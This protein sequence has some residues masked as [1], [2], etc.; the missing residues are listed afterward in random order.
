MG[1]APY[2]VGEWLPQTPSFFRGS[3]P[4]TGHTLTDSLPAIATD[5]DFHGRRSGHP[6]FLLANYQKALAIREKLAVDDPAQPQLQ[7]D[8]VVSYVRLAEMEVEP[9][10]NWQRAQA[11]LTGLAGAGLLTHA[12][13]QWLGI[14]EAKLAELDHGAQQASLPT[15][16]PSIAGEGGVSFVPARR[17]SILDWLWRR[18]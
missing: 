18:G 9:R 7:T 8:L 14:V 2:P 16:V 15:P 1:L 13:G 4:Q 5:G 11:V 6:G 17:R 10:E 3:E 12:E